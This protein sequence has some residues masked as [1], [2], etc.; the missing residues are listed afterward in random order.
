M[1]AAAETEDTRRCRRPPRGPSLPPPGPRSCRSPATFPGPHIDLAAADD[2]VALGPWVA[3]LG[4][5]AAAAVIGFYLIPMLCDCAGCAGP[6]RAGSSP[7]GGGA[8]VGEDLGG[9][10]GVLDGVE[11]GV[12]D[13]AVLENRH[14]QHPAG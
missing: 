4:M 13:E 6:R 11:G 1:P 12:A 14:R 3:L 8:E 10:V 2:G 9:T 5:A 7:G